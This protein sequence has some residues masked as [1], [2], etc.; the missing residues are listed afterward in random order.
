[1]I[2]QNALLRLCEERGSF[3]GACRP[4]I[5]LPSIGKPGF[6]ILQSNA[7]SVFGF[8][9]REIRPQGR[10]QFRSPNPDFMDLLL[11]VRLGNPKKDL[12]KTAVLKD[13]QFQ[14]P[15]RISH[16]TVERKSKNRFLSVEIRFWISRSIANPKSGF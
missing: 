8:H 7:K 2:I 16:P 9:L 5:R 15:F 11:T 1:M 3:L 14:I 6:W 10:F 13:S 12:Q 4:N